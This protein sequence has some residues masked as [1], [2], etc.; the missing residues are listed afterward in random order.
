MEKIKDFLYSL[1]FMSP[2]YYELEEEHDSNSERHLD[3]AGS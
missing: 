3:A 2:Y 1:R